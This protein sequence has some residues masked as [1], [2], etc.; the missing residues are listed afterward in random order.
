MNAAMK[1]LSKP[2]KVT[3]EGKVMTLWYTVG[4]NKN[5]AQ[6]EKKS[7]RIPRSSM[8][9]EWWADSWNVLMAR[10]PSLLPFFLTYVVLLATSFSRLIWLIILSG[11]HD[12]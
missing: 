11:L 10:W 9:N 8:Q 3:A 7:T 12:S 5:M 6:K 1:Y 4:V 2:T